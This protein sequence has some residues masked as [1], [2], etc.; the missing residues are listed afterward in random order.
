MARYRKKA[1][2][3]EAVRARDILAADTEEKWNALPE[4]VR[5]GGAAEWA[6]KWASVDAG[7]WIVREGDLL[8]AV[9]AAVFSATYE[10]VKE[11]GP[12]AAR[13][14]AGTFADRVLIVDESLPV[15][16]PLVV[17]PEVLEA[18]KKLVL[19]S[20]HTRASASI[21]VRLDM[22]SKLREAGLD[23][24]EFADDLKHWLVRGKGEAR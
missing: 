18:M 3:A 9:P 4:W 7:D 10:P 15:H 17:R 8:S 14:L 5:R 20:I 1:V 16:A 6:R 23:P 11:E 13:K 19:D 22:D 12:Q 24:A 2:E 21:P